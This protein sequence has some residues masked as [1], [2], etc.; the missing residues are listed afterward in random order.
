MKSKNEIFNHYSQIMDSLIEKSSF[1][2]TFFQHPDYMED[3]HGKDYY[4]DGIIPENLSICLGATRCCLVDSDYDYVM[5]FNICSDYTNDNICEREAETYAD[6]IA[7][8][9]SQYLTPID[10]IGTYTKTF[11]FY[12]YVD[13][14]RL[15]DW[16]DYDEDDF[17]LQLQSREEHKELRQDMKKEITI[18]FELY[19]SPKADFVNWNTIIHSNVSRTHL[20]EIT[21]PLRDR[22]EF[23][24]KYFYCLY[25][26]DE[27]SKFSAFLSE[28]N[29]NDLHPGNIGMI[30][31]H[32]CL[33]DYAGYHSSL[34]AY[35]PDE[36]VYDEEEVL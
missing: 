30:N 26:N 23:V 1:F 3:I 8:G 25:G 36:G 32:F 5:K 7:Y 33:I 18:S 16:C 31:N 17:E 14:E 19:A 13:V 2:K 6:S 28:H 11:K 22:N 12:N 27:Y 9:L 10:S 34:S 4:Q 24:G 20:P 15:I 35:S 21:S 29:V